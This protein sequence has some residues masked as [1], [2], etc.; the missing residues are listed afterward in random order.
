MRG[1]DPR[2]HAEPQV[3]MDHRVKP[4][5]DEGMD[6]VIASGAK[7]SRKAWEALGSIWIA[8]SLTLLAMTMAGRPCTRKSFLS[9]VDRRC[10]AVILP[11][12]PNGLQ[13]EH[14]LLGFDIEAVPVHVCLTRAAKH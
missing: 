14:A 3:R 9:S 4:G 12:A 11:A 8:S 7:Q 2:I 5:G 6:F 13:V 10:E 1:L